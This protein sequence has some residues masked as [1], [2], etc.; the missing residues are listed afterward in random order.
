MGRKIV[1]IAKNSDQRI[2]QSGEVTHIY[3]PPKI[4]K[5]TLVATIA[6]ELAQL[7]IRS[8]ILSTERPIELRMDAMI[9][10]HASYSQELF[11]KIFIANIFTLENLMKLIKEKTLAQLKGIDLLLI[12][13]LTAPYRGV[14]DPRAFTLLQQ[15]LASLQALAIYRK[16]AVLF[17]NQIAS[18]MKGAN[19]FRPVASLATRGYS[20]VTVKLSK[21]QDGQKDFIFENLTGEKQAVLGPF[22]ITAAGIEPFYE[23][24]D[25]RLTPRLA[26][27][28]LKKRTCK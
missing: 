20:D 22:W 3:G 2:L 18:K 1:I 11:Q 28:F 4:G 9:K 14:S 17:T 12:D 5:S 8:A 24:F 10:A 23:L 15:V 25:I 26:A 19:D 13:S 7:N 6:L 16:I 27:P 21:K